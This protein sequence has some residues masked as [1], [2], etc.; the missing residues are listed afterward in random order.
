MADGDWLTINR[1]AA[2]TRYSPLTQIS[3]DN[4]AGLTSQWTYSLNGA[5]T[6]VPVVV[7]GVMYLPAGDTVVALDGGSGEEIWVHRLSSGGPGP[8]ARASTRGVA[9]W[10]GD[11]EHA[12][13]IVFTSGARMVALDTATGEPA[14]GFGRDGAVNVGVPYGGV[15]AFYRHAAIIGA[16]VGE[17]PQGPAGNSRAFDVRTGEQLWEFQ[18]VPLPDEDY[19]HTWGDGWE[20]RSGTNMWAFSATVDDERGIAFMS[21]SSPSPNY[22]GGDRPGDNVY[23][24]SIV[25]VDAITGEK[26]WH[27]QIIRHDIWDV[28]MGSVGALFDFT[29]PDGEVRPAF[30]HV[31]KTSYLF[32]LDRETGEPLI[33]VEER[34]IPIG[35]VPGEW[36]SPTQPF[37]VRPGPLSRVAFD[38]ETDLVTPRDTSEIHVAACRELMER[39]GGFYN[40][41]PFT[42]FLYKAPDG[43]PRSTVQ[44]PGGTGGVN[45]GGIAVDRNTGYLYVNANHTSLAGWVEDRVPGGNYGRGTENSP[46]PYDR[47]SISGP[48]PY[49]SFSAPINGYDDA[50]RPV[51]PSLPCYRPPWARLVAVDPARGEIVWASTLGVNELLPEDKQLVGNAGSAGPTVTAGGL[52]FVGATNDRRFRAFSSASGE[53]LWETEVAANA[54]ANPMSYLDPDG[55]QRVAVIAGN[56]V[57]VFGLPE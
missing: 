31:G 23:G 45:W 42:S 41:G 40:A 2:A 38:V 28:D 15:P 20:Q 32:V 39:S 50:G 18:T 46:Q 33:E 9:Y 52:V 43:S 6:A 19:N 37:P 4:V 57:S 30:A 11:D 10:P 54:N 56:T 12:P 27:Y 21:I 8:G 14:A 47:G 35:D 36:Y 29:M 16:A 55:R 44:L 51:G 34:P 48:G 22:Y 3:A 17:M 5:S 13:R 26:I 53:L 7:D 24:G 1:D 25:A 49:A